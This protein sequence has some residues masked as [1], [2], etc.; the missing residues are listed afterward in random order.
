MTFNH[1]FFNRGLWMHAWRQSGWIGIIYLLAMIFSGPMLLL[2]TNSTYEYRR[3]ARVLDYMFQEDGEIAI[4]FT[5]SMSILIAIFL[6]R[7]IQSKRAVEMFHSLPVRREH[8]LTVPLVAGLAMLIVPIWIAALISGSMAGNLDYVVF[9]GD[10]VIDWA[11]SL[12]VISLFFFTFT[13][14]VGMCIGQSILQIIVTFIL[15]LLPSGLSFLYS[16]YFE[17][18]LYGYWKD[19][20]FNTYMTSW[21]PLERVMSVSIEGFSQLEGWIYLGISVL[22]IALS[23]LL[24]KLRPTEKA[25]QSIVFRYFN[26]LFRLGIML[27]SA[28]TVGIYFVIFFEK[29]DIAGYIVGGLLGYLAAEMILRKTWYIFENRLWTRLLIYGFITLLLLY[30]PVSPLNGYE[31]RV[32]APNE[33]EFVY[34]GGSI[35]NV[36]PVYN[37]NGKTYKELNQDMLASNPDYIRSIIN[38]HSQIAVNKPESGGKHDNDYYKNNEMI[39]IGYILKNGNTLFRSYAVPRTSEYNP[40]LQAVYQ[41]KDYKISFYNLKGLEKSNTE[42]KITN[43][44]KQK[45]TVTVT[46]STEIEQLKRL[47]IQEKLAVKNPNNNPIRGNTLVIQTYIMPLSNYG[48]SYHYNWNPAF[49]PTEKW[50]KQK[51]YWD[52]LVTKVE[53]LSAVVIVPYNDDEREQ[54]INGYAGLFKKYR[55]TP[56][57]VIINDKDQIDKLL[58]QSETEGR[59]EKQSYLL[60]LRF[61][62][63]TG[64]YRVLHK[65]SITPDLYKILPK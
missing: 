64:A 37:E 18:Y 63:G 45:R 58:N 23:Y 14:F 13:M 3:D 65:D 8:L 41:S 49:K 29:W 16:K 38:L 31:K 1:Y 22:L 9:T 62:D 15:L 2:S 30:I 17:R 7:Y 36:L 39:E 54:M 24:Y 57:Q 5:F 61:K 42:F 48:N 56:K 43:P 26:P 50:L 32:P 20:A 53:D 60:K 27:C 34:A 4:L 47:I 35:S 25:T 6:M 59:M 12:T 51:G 46:D 40:Y 11:V 10:Q 33:V 21:S 52:L 44:D 28:L 55:G 19:D